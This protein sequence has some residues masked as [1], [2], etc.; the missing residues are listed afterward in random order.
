MRHSARR[1]PRRRG[2]RQNPRCEPCSMT[3]G[4]F[5]HVSTLDQNPTLPPPIIPT[6]TS[7]N[8]LYCAARGWNAPF[9]NIDR[10]VSGSKDR[11][12]ALDVLVRD[13]KRQTQLAPA[14]TV[15]IAPPTLKTGRLRAQRGCAEH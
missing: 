3:A 1:R 7:P 12:P 14:A 4:L 15:K 13:A 11:R 8:C 9:E 2:A 6:T 5:Y 10:G